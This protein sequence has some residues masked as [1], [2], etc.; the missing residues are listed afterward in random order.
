MN[1]IPLYLAGAC[2]ALLL[3]GCSPSQAEKTPLNP[4]LPNGAPIA[5]GDFGMQSPVE[6]TK[7]ATAEQKAKLAAL[8]NGIYQG[9][10]QGM[11][12]AIRVTLQVKDGV[13]TVLDIWQDGET[14][15]VGGYE[16]IKDGTF[17]K[18]IEKAQGPAID[19][20]SGATITSAAVSQAVEN[21]LNKG[22][23]SHG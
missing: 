1:R 4:Y 9:Q 15:G 14:Q 8:P 16:A 23:I 19:S 12:G 11:C 6:L 3:T 10:A 18:M 20:V 22:A 2:A 5:Q 13:L 7:E 21:A 17:A